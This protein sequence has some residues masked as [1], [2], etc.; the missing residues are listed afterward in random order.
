MDTASVLWRTFPLFYNLVAETFMAHC[1][2]GPRSEKYELPANWRCQSALETQLDEHTH[3]MQNAIVFRNL[4]GN[5]DVKKIKAIAES[6]MKILAVHPLCQA[7]VSVRWHHTRWI[8]TK[9][10]TTFFQFVLSLSLNALLRETKNFWIKILFSCNFLVLCF[11]V[12][13][14]LMGF[15]VLFKRFTSLRR[16]DLLPWAIW[17][18]FVVVAI[19]T[20][21]LAGLLTSPIY[22]V[23]FPWLSLLYK[24]S[25]HPFILPWRY[26]FV[27]GLKRTFILVLVLLVLLPLGFLLINSGVCY[28]NTLNVLFKLLGDK[29]TGLYDNISLEARIA[30][31]I[32]QCELI[33]EAETHLFN[34]QSLASIKKIDFD[35]WH[36]FI[37]N[38]EEKRKGNDGLCVERM[39]VNR[40]TGECVALEKYINLEALTQAGLESRLGFP[41]ENN[42]GFYIWVNRGCRLDESI[43]QA[44]IDPFNT[45]NDSDA[46]EVLLY[47]N[48]SSD[49][50][51]GD[52]DDQEQIFDE[53]DNVDRAYA[54]QEITSMLGK[55]S[56]ENCTSTTPG[57]A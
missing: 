30:K 39:R 15:S 4:F 17:Y 52:D 38:V 56:S 45:T 25:E 53:D 33:I 3:V 55:N 42:D 7:L 16:V 12:S 24:C 57:S 2:I 48:I 26:M 1:L 28:F 49:D 34:M 40:E 47:P 18:Q 10:L 44:V 6:E 31:V 35:E 23:I 13:N 32:A 36:D 5:S 22:V 11:L 54:Q 51:S 14:E 50:D 9:K 27:Q 19:A 8:F 46:E 37:R 20:L 43:V 41:E 29:L 21:H